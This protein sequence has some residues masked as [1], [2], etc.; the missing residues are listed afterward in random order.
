MEL[1]FVIVVLILFI[2][3]GLIWNS[4]ATRGF[5]DGKKLV[6]KIK[7]NKDISK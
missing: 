2:R 4:L 7:K 5:E 6:A 1:L 3:F